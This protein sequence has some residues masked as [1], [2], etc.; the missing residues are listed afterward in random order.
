MT[1]AEI[2]ALAKKRGVALE[3]FLDKLVV[4][5][6]REP[7]EVLVCLLRDNK[8]AI[9]EAIL[10][11]ETLPE[12]WRRILAER[13]EIVV[14]RRGLP[15]PDAERE[16]FRHV[17]IEYSS[18]THRD[19]NPLRCA[20]CGRPQALGAPLLPSG[21]GARHTWL[22]SACWD[23]WRARRQAEVVTELAKIGIVEPHSSAGTGAPK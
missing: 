13:T 20:F 15:R 10:A 21:W 17:M 2:I 14:K 12:R 19:S 18:E 9:V 7:D 22:H 1:A 6:D 16:A 5:A 3:V 8:P 11:A 23:A 4:S